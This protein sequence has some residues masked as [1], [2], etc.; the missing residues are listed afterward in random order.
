M[1][2]LCAAQ[3]QSGMCL[4]Q[5]HCC[6]WRAITSQQ[7]C[8]GCPSRLLPSQT[9]RLVLLADKAG[10]PIQQ[11][12]HTARRAAA[13]AATVPVASAATAPVA[14]SATAP[15]A[16]AAAPSSEPIATA[17]AVDVAAAAAKHLGGQMDSEGNLACN[18]EKMAPSI[19]GYS[20]HPL[21]ADQLC[22]CQ[23]MPL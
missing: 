7:V 1:H 6:Y 17:T 5:E 15:V 12:V 3:L 18:G 23:R 8:H 22:L 16:S 11:S 9:A 4:L 13:T 10:C 2:L 19:N 21:T 14:S 20:H